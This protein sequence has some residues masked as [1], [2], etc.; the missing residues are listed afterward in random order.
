MK[1][2]QTTLLM[3]NKVKK[4]VEMLKVKGKRI[5]KERTLK[6]Q[7]IQKITKNKLKREEIKRKMRKKRKNS[8]NRMK[9]PKSSWNQDME[10][11]LVLLGI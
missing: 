6:L 7:P 10:E 2:N 4:K 1:V 3:E 9:S 5:P 11:E 8:N